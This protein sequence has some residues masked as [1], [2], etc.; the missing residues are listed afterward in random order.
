MCTSKGDYRRDKPRRLDLH[1]SGIRHNESAYGF[2]AGMKNLVLMLWMLLWPL[3]VVLS[4]ILEKR[5]LQRGASNSG[6]TAVFIV[7]GW[8]IGGYLLYER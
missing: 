3:A 7:A 6:A 8:I 1:N 2:G 4:E 5:F